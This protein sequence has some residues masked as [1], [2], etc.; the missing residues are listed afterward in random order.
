MHHA[1][2]SLLSLSSCYICTRFCLPP[3]T[4]TVWRTY[5]AHY[6]I[7]LVSHYNFFVCSVWWTWLSYPS[8]FFCA[9]NTHYTLSYRIVT[10]TSSAVHTS[11]FPHE[12]GPLMMFSSAISNLVLTSY[13]IFFL[14]VTC[15]SVTL[16]IKIT[17]YKIENYN[18]TIVGEPW[19]FQIIL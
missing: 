15:A 8:A 7:F 5:H 9:L 16:L 3:T 18:K 1:S 10:A 12:R 4:V 2:T 14:C 6:F 19:K 17:D 11:T 13:Y